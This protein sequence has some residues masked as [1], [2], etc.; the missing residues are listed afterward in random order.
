[1]DLRVSLHPT[2][3]PR[4][5]AELL[6]VC[7]RVVAPTVGVICSNAGPDADSP[8]HAPVHRRD[9]D[10]CAI[11]VAGIE[12]DH[13]HYTAGAG[14][15]SLGSASLIA[16]RAGA[17][18]LA[19]M[20]LEASG[21]LFALYLVLMTVLSVIGIITRRTSSRPPAHAVAR[22]TASLWVTSRSRIR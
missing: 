15:A 5:A 2:A 13:V 19:K 21:A 12:R 3:R 7:V 4:F 16:G 17:A 1:M 9:E 14:L 6:V 18:P 22:S 8:F 10:A 20:L 11:A